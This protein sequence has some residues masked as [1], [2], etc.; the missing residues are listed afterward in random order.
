MARRRKA[1]KRRRKTFSILSALESLIYANILTENIAGANVAQFV[2]GNQA[3]GGSGAGWNYGGLGGSGQ[4]IAEVIKDPSLI[5]VMANRG[6]EN[7]VNIVA[8][9]FVTGLMFRFGKRLMRRQ[10]SSINRNLVRP[11]LGAGVRI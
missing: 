6:S 7:F 5:M 10:L 3:P 8:Q 2:L 4:S 9:S 11:A 1:P